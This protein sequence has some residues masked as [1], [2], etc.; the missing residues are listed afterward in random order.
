MTE[1]TGRDGRL[2]QM[3]VLPLRFLNGFLFGINAKQAK[4]EIRD[5]VI[6]GGNSAK[7]RKRL[8]AQALTPHKERRAF[9]AYTAKSPK[10]RGESMTSAR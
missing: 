10:R 6:A 8:A 5:G 2:Y 3:T 9:P 1:A 7:G 4:A